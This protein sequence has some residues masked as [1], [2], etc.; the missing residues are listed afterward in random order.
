MWILGWVTYSTLSARD[1]AASFDPA[2]GSAV[3]W[4]MTLAHRRAV[5]RNERVPEVERDV[6]DL[7][8][9]PGGRGG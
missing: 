1:T 9:P 6:P 5:D 7:I 8:E 3:T 4:L 2:R